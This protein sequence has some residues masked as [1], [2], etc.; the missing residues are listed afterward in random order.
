MTAS[1]GNDTLSVSVCSECPWQTLLRCPLPLYQRLGL[2]ISRG[3][4]TVLLLLNPFG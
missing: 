3:I 4:M 1:T 2:S